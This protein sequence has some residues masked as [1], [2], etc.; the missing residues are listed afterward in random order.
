VRTGAEYR[1]RLKDGRKVWVMGEGLVDDITTHPATAG[2][3]DEYAAWYDRHF[4][5]A[6]QDDLLTTPDAAGRRAPVCFAVPYSAQDL[7]RL[8][9]AVERQ[10]FVSAGNVTHTPAYGALIALGVLDAAKTMGEDGGGRVAVAEA[11][12]ERLAREGTFLTLTGGAS[13]LGDRFREPE[14][15][16]GLRIV[17]ETD[18]GIVVSGRT[19]MHTSTPFAEEVYMGLQQPD[20]RQRAM[21]AVAVNSPGAMVVTRRP[22]VRDRNRFMSPLSTRFDELEGQLWLENVLVPWEKVFALRFEPMPPAEAQTRDRIFCWL[23]WHHQHTWLARA[24]FTLGLALAVTDAM[25]MRD[26][27]AV[28][29]QLVD[30][31]IDCQTMRSCLTAA[32]Y[33]ATLSPGGF[34]MPRPLHVAAAAIYTFR[35]RQR[36]SEILRGL[37][38]SSLVFRPT[39]IDLA[40]ATMAAALERGF[41]GGGYS[42]RQRAALFSLVWDHV[43]SSLDGRESAF[44]MHA[45]GG[46]PVWRNRV[47]RWFAR[48]NE[49]ANRVLEALDVEMPVVNL[50]SLRDIPPGRPA[51]APPS[52]R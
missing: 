10:A 24:D 49:L 26:S 44:E 16:A 7:L 6:W 12:R 17:T 2:M 47:Q 30:L 36:M 21:F 48:Y 15:R 34:A 5:P 8:G 35:V 32:S 19:G 52:N 9:T 1:E 37:P 39:D 45:S 22:S 13:I 41:G 18:A 27:R 33:D 43:S 3:V 11:Y 50:E 42:A 28:V 23:T 20:P 40:D 4:D 38:G 25:G 14:D 46:M 31:I 51:P 29:D